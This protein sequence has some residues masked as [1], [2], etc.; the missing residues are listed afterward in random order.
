MKEIIYLDTSFLHSFIAQ[1][2]SGLPT[3]IETETSDSE[4]RTSG[5]SASRDKEHEL[6]LVGDTGGLDLWIY[7]APSGKL[8][9]RQRT[10]RSNTV[11]STLS[12]LEAGREIISR[13]LHDNALINFE[14]YLKENDLLKTKED[15]FL[16]GD[17]VELK[18]TFKIIDFKYLRT[19]LD[20]NLGAMM[21]NLDVETEIEQQVMMVDIDPQLNN[22]Q[23]KAKKKE[24]EN[25]YKQT[26]EKTK[27]QFKR[28]NQ[29][30]EY[31]SNLMP[32][33]AFLKVGS[34]LVP[35]KGSFLREGASELNFKYGNNEEAQIQLTVLGKVTRNIEYIE[36]N[37][38][39]GE[40]FQTV[41]QLTNGIMTMLKTIDV[42]EDG[43]AIVS[44]IAVYFD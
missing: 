40:F 34:C 11:S 5:E 44:P 41:S 29:M 13:Q 38:E 1:T 16:P 8:G 39:S 43:D 36:E 14:D 37:D 18:S 7:S 35:L 22:N 21:A 26:T 28:F 17:Y 2:N 32:T 12:Q 4:T 6:D 31:V 23:K 30:I 3:S 24:I 15:A 25:K 33:D 27:A 42:I 20:E 19:A 10:R 9:Y